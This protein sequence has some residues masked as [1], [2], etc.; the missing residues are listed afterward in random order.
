VTLQL[1]DLKFRR[2]ILKIRNTLYVSVPT[3]FAEADRLERGNYVTITIQPDG[4]LKIAKEATED[5]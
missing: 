4:S 5:E 2:K 1:D 3:L